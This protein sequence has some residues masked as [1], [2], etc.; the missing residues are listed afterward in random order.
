MSNEQTPRMILNMQ[1]AAE[2]RESVLEFTTDL[3]TMPNNEMQL[4]S[5]HG[6]RVG[7]RDLRAV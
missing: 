1:M 3:G 4:S 5:V 6:D 2:P 7:D